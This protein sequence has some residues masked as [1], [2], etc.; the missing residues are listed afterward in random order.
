M[1][2]LGL[3][4]RFALPLSAVSDNLPM[5]AIFVAVPLIL[6]FD[7]EALWATHASA[8]AILRVHQSVDLESCNQRLKNPGTPDDSH[9]PPI[10]PFNR[11]P[12]RFAQ[13]VHLMR[14]ELL[15]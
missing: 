1:P 4:C 13:Q 8:E 7:L 6:S 14:R 5:L 11:Q 10:L 2:T 9:W 3:L 12:H 15:F